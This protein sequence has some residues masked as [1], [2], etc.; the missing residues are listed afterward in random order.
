MAW[1]PPGS[2]ELRARVRF[3]RR[4]SSQNV[5]GVVRS[6]WDLLIEQRRGRLQAARGGEGVQADRLAGISAW[7]LDIRQDPAT[8]G[9]TS[10]D[11]AVDRADPTRCFAIR[12]ILD[13][14]GRGRW[15]TLTLELGADDGVEG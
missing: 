2:G 13:L 10:D 5:G 4:G 8:R 3:E 6:T 7:T 14:E 1:S 15:F 9:L 11:R 12:S